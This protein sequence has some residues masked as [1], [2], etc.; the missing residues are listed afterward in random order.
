MACP[1]GTITACDFAQFL[2]DQTPRFDEMIMEDVRLTDGWIGHVATGTV[3]AG[4]PSEITQDR[5]RAVW[6]NTTKAWRRVPVAGPGCTGE[7]CDPPTACIGW[8]ADRLTYFEEEITYETPLFCYDQLMNVTAA[9]QH[10]AQI[11]NKIL[12]PNTQNIFSMFARKRGLFWAKYKQAAN[13]LLSAFTYEWVSAD[14][15]GDGIVDDEVY[16]DAS[17]PP[18]QLF[19]LVPQMLQNNWSRSMREGYA[20]ENPFKETAPF[21]ELVTDMD[22]AWSLDKLGGQ[23]GVGAANNPNVASNWRFTE[24]G[25]A[26]EYWRYG[27]SGQIGNYMVRVDEMG[28]RFNYVA[29]LGAGAH[30]GNGNRY[31]YQLILPYVNTTTTGAGGAA[32][33]GSDVNEDFDKSHFRISYQWHKKG[34]EFL[35]PDNRS[36]NPEMP[37]AHRDFGGKWRFLMHDL[38][39]DTTGA[40]ITNKWENK[41][42]F[43]A[44]FKYYVR[45]L[46]YEFLRGYLH[47]GEQFCIPEI[48]VCSDDPGYP[49]QSYNSCPPVCPAPDGIYGTGVPTGTQDG[50][51]E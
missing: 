3:P 50:P 1:E 51:I 47:K 48:D 24:W 36:L 6:A 27:F 40:P 5:F 2:V 45:P 37:F 28:L 44:W 18:T 13:A 14:L 7:P 4:T 35:V 25:A 20:G 10:L 29:D 39:P 30:G 26:N 15:D 21:I 38:G 43:G 42:Q 16:F 23:Q 46:H 31:R 49:E 12:R 22:T 32:G 41:G 19:K 34:L 8:G 11:V 33:I 17:V 9:E